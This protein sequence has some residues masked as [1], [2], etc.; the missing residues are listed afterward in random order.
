MAHVP[1]GDDRGLGQG[2][3]A[4]LDAVLGQHEDRAD[5]DLVVA[6]IERGERDRP[7]GGIDG[8]HPRSQ[9]ESDLARLD[10]KR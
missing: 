2:C 1:G 6:E 10:M 3:A 5:L 7:C 4:A 8:Q 9:R